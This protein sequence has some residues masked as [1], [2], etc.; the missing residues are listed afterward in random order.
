MATRLVVMQAQQLYGQ[1]FM[2]ITMPASELDKVAQ[3]AN[4]SLLHYRCNFTALQCNFTALQMQFYCV[5]LHGMNN[6][7]YAQ[8]E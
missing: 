1:S 3:M 5:V 2:C 8:H 7:L 6:T 4:V